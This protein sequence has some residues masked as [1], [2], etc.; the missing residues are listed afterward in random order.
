MQKRILLLNAGPRTRRAFCS[1]IT[2]FDVDQ[3]RSRELAL[4]IHEDGAIS[5]HKEN[6]EID[7]NYAYIFCRLF[8][9]DHMFGSILN[10]HFAS[11]G[12]PL[13]D[14]VAYTVA[15]DKIVQMP[16]F[17]RD[18]IRVPETFIVR[19]ESFAANKE[20]I[21]SKLTFPVV[22]KTSGS[23]GRNVAKIESAGALEETF[24]KKKP[25]ARALIQTL[26]PNT[27]DT[28]TLVAYGTV[29]GTI[30]RSAQNG[31]FLNNVSQGAAIEAYDLMPEEAAIAI[32]AT[33]ICK[34]DFGGVDIIHTATGPCVLEV[35]RSPQIKGF[36][37]IYGEGSVFRNIAKLIEEQYQ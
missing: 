13:S 33:A 21:L 8:G 17:A 2:R 28:R 18:G 16:R 14:P 10:E 32:K 11:L 5:L 37:R 22:F 35:N 29:L 15:D 7:T 23:Q 27:Y 4:H 3:Y 36:E 30:K 24:A 25:H 19:E 20:Y 12:I 6:Q 34:L 26:I 9:T 1:G 31:N